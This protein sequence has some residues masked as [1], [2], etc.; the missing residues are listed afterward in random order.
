[1]RAGTVTR[2]GGEVNLS[3]VIS[4]PVEEHSVL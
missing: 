3:Q 4:L 1:M 2:D